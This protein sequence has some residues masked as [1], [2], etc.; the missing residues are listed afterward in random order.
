MFLSSEMT[1]PKSNFYSLFLQVKVTSNRKELLFYLNYLIASDLRVYPL[2]KEVKM[3]KLLRVQ[4]SLTLP[5][6][7]AL[8]LATMYNYS[9][10][11][12]TFIWNMASYR[13]VKGSRKQASLLGSMVALGNLSMIVQQ[14]LS[15]KAHYNDCCSCYFPVR[16]ILYYFQNCPIFCSCSGSSRFA[17]SRKSSLLLY[18][19]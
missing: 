13:S 19:L 18:R 15:S 7:S 1:Q 16:A 6:S 11:F 14:K 10:A 9:G 12:S 17:R 2:T 3:M 8:K 4:S 5:I